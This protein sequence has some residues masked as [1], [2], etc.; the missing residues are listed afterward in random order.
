MDLGYLI[1]AESD[2]Y[3]IADE[4]GAIQRGWDYGCDYQVLYKFQHPLT[5]RDMRADPYLN[6]WGAL[7]ASFQMSAYAIPVSVWQ[8]LLSLMEKREPEFARFLKRGGVKRVYEKIILE[9]ELERRIAENPGV[10]RPFGYDVEVRERQLTCGHGGRI[11]LLCYD[12]KR[13]RYVVIE[14]KN[15]RAGKNTFSQIADYIGWV[16][17]RISHGR[18]VE[19]LVIARG[20]DNHFLSAAATNDRVQHIDLEQLGFK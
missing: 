8:R 20:F 18:P 10:L 14:L 16:R 12:L 19:G 3:S 4:E 1:Q 15:V 7:K 9:E 5:L 13:K 6:E 11:D 2:A 17:R